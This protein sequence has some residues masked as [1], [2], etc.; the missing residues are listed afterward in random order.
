[1]I[2]EVTFKPA[3]VPTKRQALNSLCLIAGEMIPYGKDS[4]PKQFVKKLMETAAAAGV[5]DEL[6]AC[7]EAVKQPA[8][9]IFDESLLAIFKNITSYSASDLEKY[10]GCP[11]Q[12]FVDKWLRPALMEEDIY[13]REMGSIAHRILSK[14]G[15]LIR[16]AGDLG[17]SSDKLDAALEVMDQLLAEEC[18]A[19]GSDYQ[20]LKMKAELHYY[21][22]QFV[23]DEAKAA[24]GLKPKLFEC[25]FDQRDK[26][27][28]WQQI[29]AEL[30]LGD[31]L[32][33]KGRMDR[34]DIE[35]GEVERPR[36]IVIDY[37]VSTSVSGVLKFKD[38]GML[39]VPLYILALQNIWHLNP[40]G[41]YYYGLRQDKNNPRRGMFNMDEAGC[42][43]RLK[44]S[45]KDM[46]SPEEF[47]AELEDALNRARLA[48]QKI[49]AGD[50][51]PA[52][53]EGTCEY[54]DYD[55][56]CRHQK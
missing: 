5:S 16:N 12:Y 39:Q 35:E 19:F 4:P 18:Q 45:E 22:R 29:C 46:L 36:A 27:N 2:S 23:K 53:R 51:A 7:L 13:W 50:F 24:T 1:L 20:S 31:G 54:C 25:S 11:Y 33:L 21:L 47:K 56:L 28:G 40:V 43:G 32:T 14:F 48:A 37:K 30:N 42:F 55:L 52:P 17:S 44:V 6:N 26:N 38:K 49:Q 3:E 41:G 9:G 8:F 10:A 15:R 34:V